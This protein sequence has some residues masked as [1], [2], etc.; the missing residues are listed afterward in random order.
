MAPDAPAGEDP[1]PIESD[2]RPAREL[3]RQ[4]S[5]RPKDDNKRVLF[6]ISCPPDARHGGAV[7]YGRWA[8]MLLPDLA[9]PA[10]AARFAVRD[11]FYDYAPAAEPA[12]FS[13]PGP[14]AAEWHVHFADPELF[15][16]YGTAV[17]VQDEWQVVEHPALAALKEARDAFGIPMRTVER[18]RPTPILIAGA[19]RR[20]RFATDPNAAEGRPEGLYGDNFSHAPEVAIRRATTVIDPPTT[21]NFVA[22]SA[23]RGGRGRYRAAEIDLALA[24]AFTGFRAAVVVSRRGLPEVPPGAGVVVHTGFWGCGVFGGNRVMMTVVQALAAQM[25]GVDLLVFHVGDAAG[26][27]PVARARTILRDV[28]AADAADASIVAPELIRRI[29]SLGLEWGSGDGS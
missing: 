8:E 7:R 2:W 25:A 22:I 28:L 24:T 20:I 15:A 18:G 5:P 6:G 27:G 14:P 9:R 21:T 1:Q 11:G 13:E 26:R 16:L 17:F 10:G 23:P 4:H 19:E 3:M 29:E 12:T